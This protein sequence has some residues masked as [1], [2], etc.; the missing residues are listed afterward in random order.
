[1]S[2]E[3]GHNLHDKSLGLNAI[4]LDNQYMKDKAAASKN[5][6]PYFEVLD[7]LELPE[8]GEG[9]EQ[10]LEN[11][12]RVV[13]NLDRERGDQNNSEQ[14]NKKLAMLHFKL[15]QF[16]YSR[17]HRLDEIASSEVQEAIETKTGL[18]PYG[19]PKLL[20]CLDGRVLSKLFAGLHGNALRMP[21]GDSS[22]FRPRRHGKG[23]FLADGQ[24]SNVVDEVLKSQD[25][26][27]EVLDSHVGCAA[28]NLAAE[29][30][31]GGAVPDK[32]LSD[33][34]RRKRDMAVAL[35]KYVGNKY[36]GEKKVVVLQTSFDPHSG[37]MYMGLEK[38]DCLDHDPRVTAEG[39]TEN[40]INSLVE[41]GKIIYA[42]ELADNV[43]RDLFL[44]NYFA[45]NYET[46]YVNSTANFWNKIKA[47]SKEAL[48]IVKEKLEQVFSK[49]L[50]GLTDQEREKQIEQRAV[51]LLANAYNAFLH[52]Y[53]QDGSPRE[54]AYEKHDESVVVVT[55]SE[56]GP[57]DRA[58]SFSLNPANPDL[59]G[60][61]NLAKGLIQGNRRG[62]RMSATEKKA[63]ESLYGGKKEDYVNNPIPII[64][65]E[66]LEIS[67]DP[68]VLQKLQLADWSD[69]AEKNWMS[70]SEQEFDAYLEGKVSNI[71]LKVARK[72]NELRQRAISLY[73]PGQKSTEALLDGRL[74]P[75]WV[76]TGPDRRTLAMLPFVAKG[77]EE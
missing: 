30:K 33:D 11:Y 23:L 21:A 43:F 52:N 45:I 24:I 77:Y 49:E 2:L 13:A 55:L 48:P 76:L 69:L 14:E 28:R 40:N 56:K 73:K 1:M 22:E 35:Q 72:I 59:S 51:L 20:L 31:K 25:E 8:I 27:C 32:G 10:Q 75:V 18:F 9:L 34:V 5:K 4:S 19:V 74:V 12:V 15:C 70:M 60:D 71:P 47:M 50:V 67:P 54:Y 58:R 68:L 41:E 17:D 37:Y 61:I 42:K 53:N 29:E 65:F 6:E 62:G 3:N 16:I 39:F 64:L 66:R 26:V 7:N 38:A 36:A 63:V 46:D 44:K 57:F